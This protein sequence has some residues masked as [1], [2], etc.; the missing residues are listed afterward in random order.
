MVCWPHT[1]M[2]FDNEVSVG[3]TIGFSFSISFSD[4]LPW[5]GV[6]LFVTGRVGSQQIL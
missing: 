4:G 3:G 2:Y 5:L 6:D 1:I